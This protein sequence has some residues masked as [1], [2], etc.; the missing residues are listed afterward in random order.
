MNFGLKVRLLIIC[1]SGGGNATK[2]QV[3]V[4]QEGRGKLQWVFSIK[5][6]CIPLWLM[7][8]I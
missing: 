4:L 2:S 5:G 6:N 7:L 3:V 1:L 8:K